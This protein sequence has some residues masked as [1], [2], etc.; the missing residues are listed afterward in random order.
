MSDYVIGSISFSDW[1]STNTNN[2]RK[3][4]SKCACVSKV[5]SWTAESE[6]AYRVYFSFPGIKQEDVTVEFSRDGSEMYI[7]VK[8][9][10]S[11]VTGEKVEKCST[12]TIVYDE[13]RTII[14]EKE[15][16]Q[17]GTKAKYRTDGIL[18]IYAPFSKEVEKRKVHVE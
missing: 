12:D 18:E 16:D 7:N 13:E 15:V 5:R 6:D 9:E 4:V 11:L 10:R 3:Q 8:A 1:F 17:A 14:F 2:Y